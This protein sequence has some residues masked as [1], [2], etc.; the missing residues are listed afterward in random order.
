MQARASQAQ[1]ADPP[2]RLRA[3]RLVLCHGRCAVGRIRPRQELRHQRLARRGGCGNWYEV[4]G[5]HLGHCRLPH[6][7]PELGGHSWLRMPPQIRS[8]AHRR[9]RGCL[10]RPVRPCARNC[11]HMPR[12]LASPD[13]GHAH[14][15]GM[16]TVVCKGCVDGER[17]FTKASVLA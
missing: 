1:V 2:I 7:R 3:P 17:F 10:Q 14:H 5:N 12:Q 4:G 11:R 15:P 9:P 6:G 13:A 8:S 16:N